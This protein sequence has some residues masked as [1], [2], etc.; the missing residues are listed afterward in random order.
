MVV[1]VVDF[2]RD[3]HL[4]RKSEQWLIKRHFEDLKNNSKHKS[5]E[6]FSELDTYLPKPDSW[7][8]FLG[9]KTHLLPFAHNKVGRGRAALL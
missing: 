8:S 4:A 5:Y 2:F 7:V 9:T 3:Q 1:P 6:C